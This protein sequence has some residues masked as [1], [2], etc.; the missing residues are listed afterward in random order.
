MIGADEEMSG[1]R[2]RQ[3]TSITIAPTDE[4][5]AVRVLGVANG[6]DDSELPPGCDVSV[7]AARDAAGELVGGVA[8]EYGAALDVVHWLVVVERHR[9]RGVATRLL[10]VLEDEA[11]RRGVRRLWTTA[12]AP[13]VFFANG[14]HPVE[15]GAEHEMLFRDCISCPQYGHGC[16][17]RVMVK[18]LGGGAVEGQE[19]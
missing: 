3:I 10:R 11:R 18:E 16:T 4:L 13:G 9:G 19:E 6:L 1:E 17:P 8:L 5:Q 12:R 15:E 7:W 14:Y 2:E